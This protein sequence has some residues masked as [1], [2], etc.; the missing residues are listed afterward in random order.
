MA[1]AALATFLSEVSHFMAFGIMRRI[2]ECKKSE[3]IQISLPFLSAYAYSPIFYHLCLTSP[4]EQPPQKL[5]FPSVCNIE[6]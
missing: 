6:V 1:T 4:A 2:K 3:E 5:P